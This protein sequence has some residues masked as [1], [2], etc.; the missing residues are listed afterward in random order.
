MQGLLVLTVCLIA[1]FRPHDVATVPLAL[2]FMAL[3]AIVFA[4]L[5]TAIGSSL[6]DMQ[7]FQMIMNFLVMPIFFL[8]GALFPLANLPA[9]GSSTVPTF[10]VEQR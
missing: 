2:L 1:G 6:R 5:G 9:E 10:L 7:G 4:A 3:I 8:S